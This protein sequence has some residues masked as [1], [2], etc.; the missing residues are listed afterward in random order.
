MPQNYSA[1]GFDFL[2]PDGW[3]IEDEN[4]NDS[5]TVESPS[6]AFL[7][8]SKFDV[9][10]GDEEPIDKAKRAMEEEYDE[11]EQEYVT[12][13][14]SGIELI[15][16][17]QRFVYLDLIITSNLLTFEFDGATYLLQVQAED[18]E[19]ESLG[20]VFEAIMTS[21]CKSLNG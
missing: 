19:S 14:F 17:I 6:G 4:E 9:T 2:Y 5:F 21:M 12:K 3:K 15:G 10:E 20:P 7:A 16:L 18:R 13:N 11:I 8:V 1:L